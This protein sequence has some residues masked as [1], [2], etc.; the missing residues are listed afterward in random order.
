[1]AISVSFAH[2][3]SKDAERISSIEEDC[4]ANGGFIMFP[5]RFDCT[6]FYDKKQNFI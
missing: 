6:L 5:L 4:I 1:M 3:E 2:T